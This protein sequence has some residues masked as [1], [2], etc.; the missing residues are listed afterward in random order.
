MQ[1]ATPGRAERVHP[2]AGKCCPVM[3]EGRLGEPFGLGHWRVTAVRS[4]HDPPA[5]EI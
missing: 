5:G 1:V 2:W 3:E 4:T